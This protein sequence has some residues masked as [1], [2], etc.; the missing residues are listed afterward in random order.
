LFAGVSTNCDKAFGSSLL[1]G[2]KPRTRTMARWKM[3]GC[4]SLGAL[5][6]CSDAR[7]GSFYHSPLSMHALT[8]TSFALR[9]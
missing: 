8:G 5:L 7:S 3:N 2:T 6:F 4:A 1:P 9:S